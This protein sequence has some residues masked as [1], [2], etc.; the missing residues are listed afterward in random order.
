[1]N[2]DYA[3]GYK[4]PPRE[5]RFKPGNQAARGRKRKKKEGLSIS[6]IIGKAISAKRK[7][8]RGNE[9]I[10]MP[11][12]EILVERLI[13]AMTQGTAKDMALIIN[14]LERYSPD[15]LTGEVEELKVSY[16]RAEGSK[17]PLPPADL[18]KGRKP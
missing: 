5:H 10:D 3:V 17:V 1:M 6:Q 9:I 11:V 4:K 8:K 18:W 16:H 12:A 2:R 13:Q 7:I 14:L 15:L